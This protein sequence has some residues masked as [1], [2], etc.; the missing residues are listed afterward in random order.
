[1]SN[2]G[3]WI[4]G[5][6]LA[7]F[8]FALLFVGFAFFSLIG[9]VATSTLDENFEESTGT[10]NEAVAVVVLA[11]PILESE[12][13]IKQLR[14]WQN[15]S[16]VRAI[17]LRLDSPGGAVAP[18]QEIFQEV[19]RTVGKGKPVVVSMGSVAASGAYYIAC[20]ATKIVA[21]PGTI[22]GSIGVI[23]Q[24]T[25]VSKLMQKVGLE[26]TTVKSGKFKDTGS[27]MR[28]MTKEDVE[29]I[30]GLIDDVYGQFLEDVAGARKM[31]IDEVKPHADG[32]VFTGRQAY[33]FG[34]VD[35]LGTLQTAIR[36]AATLG[37]IEGEPRV[38]REHKRSSMFE[39]VFGASAK[40]T[41]HEIRTDLRSQPMLEYRLSY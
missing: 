22:T 25:D 5:I 17:V 15:R 19:K 3:K 9:A 7:V 35:T 2:S 37:R 41:L 14:T 24:F 28:P 11:E 33:T 39:R 27:P 8:G 29:Q 1:M 30:Q 16:S 23:S 13:I 31:S 10:G 21:N 36:I 4:I 34:L 32:R 40:E 12:S 18:S 38:I 26:N 20:A 6:G